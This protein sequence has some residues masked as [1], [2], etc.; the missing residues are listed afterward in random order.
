VSILFLVGGFAF[1]VIF[2]LFMMF[3][4]VP[5]MMDRDDGSGGGGSRIG[6]NEN[7]WGEYM[8]EDDGQAEDCSLETQSPPSY[9][10]SSPPSPTSVVLLRLPPHEQQYLLHDKDE[11]WHDDETGIP[12]SRINS[13]HQQQEQQTCSWKYV[14]DETW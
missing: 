9:Q 7:E 3:R 4:P 13:H 10:Q 11:E 14:W 1:L 12:S 5:N 8:V 2:L 6:E